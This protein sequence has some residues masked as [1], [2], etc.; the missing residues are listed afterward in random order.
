VKV[1]YTQTSLR[2]LN[3]I[4]NYIAKESG[5][6]EVADRYISRIFDACDALEYSAK[7]F[8]PFRYAQKWQMIPF[9][10]YLVLFRIRND[11]V[12]IGRVRHASRKP[13]RG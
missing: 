4:R 2:D 10:K 12:K 8:S 11:E 1:V 6:L 9:E 3:Q 5:S 13:F 7:S